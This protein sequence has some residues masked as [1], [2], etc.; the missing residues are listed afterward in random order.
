MRP[1]SFRYR[2]HIH[3]VDGPLAAEVYLDMRGI[4]M[5]IAPILITA[6]RRVPR[7]IYRLEGVKV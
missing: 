3:F 4:P 1:V 2:D 5:F 6:G 7:A